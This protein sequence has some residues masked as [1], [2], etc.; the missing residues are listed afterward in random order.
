[1]NP[2]DHQKLDVDTAAILHVDT[3]L[4]LRDE[5]KHRVGRELLLRI[6]SMRIQRVWRVGDPG[7]GTGT[8][9]GTKGGDRPS[10]R[11]PNDSLSLRALCA[12][13]ALAL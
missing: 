2:F 8:G 9:T 10:R 3:H 4:V 1:M 12:R 11:L 6:I 7:T 13:K 5:P